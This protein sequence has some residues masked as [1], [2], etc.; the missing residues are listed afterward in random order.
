[1]ANSVFTAQH[2][3]K[4]SQKQSINRK[5]VKA[6]QQALKKGKKVSNKFKIVMLGA[7]GAGKTSSV[8]SLL[9]KAFQKNQPS[10]VGA[11]VNTCTAERI[12]AATWKQVEIQHQ[13]EHLPKQFKSK[14]KC[15]VLQTPEESLDQTPD[16]PAASI[17]REKE[18]PQEHFPEEI[19][20][21]IVAKIQEV[22]DTQEVHNDDI[23]ITILDLGGQEIYYHIH[24]LFLAEEDVVFIAFNALQDLDQPVVCRQRLTRF[25]KKVETRGMQTNLQTIEMLMQSVYSHCGKDVDGKIYASNRIPTIVL[26]ATHSKDLSTQQKN[27]IVS[28]FFESFEGK[29]F[30][31]HLPRS[32]K[33]A[34][35]FVDNSA[36]DPQV[37]EALQAVALKAAA[38]TIAKECPISYLQFE[39]DILKESQSKAV[40]SKQEALAIAEKAGLQDN[41]MEVLNHY[42][43][44]GTLL[45]YP[46]VESLQNEVFISPQEVS[47]L[48]S[49]VISTHN[50]EPS[51]AKLQ[52]V[53][54]RYDEFGLLEED[55]LDDMLQAVGRYKDKGTILGFLQ[56][57]YL[58]VE[59]SRDTKFDKEKESYSLPKS[60]RVFLVPSMLIYNP[61]AVPVAQKGDIILSHHFPDLFLPENVFNQ[62]LVKMVSWCNQHDHHVHRLVMLSSLFTTFNNCICILQYFPWSW[63]FPV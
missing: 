22:V 26:I 37:F 53:Y 8:H 32:T 47:D 12:F 10:T 43:L 18:A 48:V 54:R 5:T 21:E 4:E 42:T 55:L 63:L 62:V 40:I 28:I 51:S 39:I 16:E 38:P 2:T 29:P 17:P 50:C 57:F 34:V 35:F 6:Y 41:L 13:L 49:S 59:V 7:E 11:A 25:Q 30:M 19:S 24:F 3:K 56:K 33:E 20:H 1:M 44:K 60:G 23:Q 61:K 36:R 52:K 31:D 45:Y 27:A 46:E 14:L 15:F 58:A 9:N